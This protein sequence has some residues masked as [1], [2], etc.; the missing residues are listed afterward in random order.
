MRWLVPIGGAVFGL[1]VDDGRFALIILVWL[2][3]VAW[4]QSL[5]PLPSPARGLALFAGLA[6]ALVSSC[7]H[8]VARRARPSQ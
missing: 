4:L 6:L 3:A 8:H 1:F 2:A 7:L 5:V